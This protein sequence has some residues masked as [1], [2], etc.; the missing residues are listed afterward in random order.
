MRIESTTCSVA[1]CATPQILQS[2]SVQGNDAGSEEVAIASSGRSTIAIWDDYQSSVGNPSLW[3]ALSSGG[4]FARSRAVGVHGSDPALVGAL[5]GQIFAAWASNGAGPL[6]VREWTGGSHL[7][8]SPV[9]PGSNAGEQPQLAIAGDALSVAWGTG[10]D[11]FGASSGVLPSGPLSVATRPLTAQ[12]FQATQ[13]VSS[14]ARD[15]TL[16][17]APNG[18]LVLAF[19]QVIP[20]TAGQDPSEEAA[21]TTRGPGARFAAP[22]ILETNPPSIDVGP[23]A[24]ITTTGTAIVEWYT[25]G[26]LSGDIQAATVQPGATPS[27]PFELGVG[28][29][30]LA[31]AAYGTSTIL[32]WVGSIAYQAQIGSAP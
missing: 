23:A 20:G 32:T 16:A 14:D 27:A 24:A 5:G 15:F 19:G 9:P 1:R 22:M 17:G 25:G 30:P 18:R 3:W 7:V 11:G 2:L 4:R 28:T 10:L 29:V 21:V 26:Y 12:K 13:T 8:S 6:S 31:A